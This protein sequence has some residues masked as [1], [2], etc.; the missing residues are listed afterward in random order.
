MKISIK[1]DFIFPFIL[2]IIFIILQ[3]LN[4]IHWAWYWI[5]SPIW[6]MFVIILF[7]FIIL[8]LKRW[9]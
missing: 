7:V 2:T 5:I 8:K 9:I 1:F 6:I 4:I 3:G